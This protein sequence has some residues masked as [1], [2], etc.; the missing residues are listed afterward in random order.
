M[1]EQIRTSPEDDEGPDA[2]LAPPDRLRNR[3]DALAGINIEG[4]A[5]ELEST[6]LHFAFKHANKDAALAALAPWSPTVH[7]AFAT[8]VGNHP[9]GL[10]GVLDAL[11]A[12][13][14]VPQSVLVLAHEDKHGRDVLVSIGVDRDVT[15]QDW[16]DL[17]GW[18]DPDDTPAT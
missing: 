2:G 7:H 3:L 11:R 8:L 1:H 14:Y 16:A 9:G 18:I 17:G 5:P 10:R 4:L 15:A 13:D 6:H 12:R